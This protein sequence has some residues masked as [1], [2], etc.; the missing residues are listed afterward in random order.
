MRMN[1]IAALAAGVCMVAMATPAQAQERS[2]NIPAG[3]LRSALDAFGRQSGKPII[4]KVDEIRGLRTNG[5][6][7][8][9]APQVALDAI[10]SGTGF[11]ARVAG[12]GAVAIMKTGNVSAAN[13]VPGEAESGADDDSSGGYSDIVVTAQKREERLVDVPISIVA[14]GADE[15]AKREING[16]D[17]LTTAVPGLSVQSAGAWTRRITI[18]GISNVFGASSL[19]G[20]YVDEAS[21]TSGADLQLDL[22]T[23]DL[24]RVEVL[25]GPQG[26]LY[27]EGSVGGTIRFIT[28][29]PQ[30]SNF[31]LT[32]DATASFTEDGAPSQRVEAAVNVP[33]VEDMFGIRVAGTFDHQGGWI[34]Q[35]AASRDNFNSQN[36]TDVRIKALLK[37]SADFRA[38]AMVIIHRNDA[39]TN[40]GE[41]ANGNYLQKFNQLTTPSVTDDFD[42]YNLTLSYDLS[43]VRLLSTS[44]YIDQARAQRN[45]GYILPTG[46]APA[47][48]LDV[49]KPLYSR[50]SQIFSQELRLTSQSGRPWQWTLG[51]FYRDATIDNYNTFYFGVPGA[52]G[53][54]LPGLV[55]APEHRVYESYALFGDTSYKLGRLTLGAGLR[56]FHEDQTLQTA[57]RQTGAFKSFN[58]RVYAQFALG[59]DAN[60]YAS[61]AKGFRSGGFNALNQPAFEP[62][63]VW[64]YELG[65]KA[66]LA[67][68]HLRGDVALFY[69]DY[70]NYQINGFLP[71]PAPPINIFRNA[72]SARIK[73]LEWGLTWTPT[74]AWTFGF[75]G[76]VADTEFYKINTTS[77]SYAVGDPL[78]LFPKYSFTVSAQHNFTA[79]DK[80]GFIRLD[81]N[82]VGRM[83]FRNR[84]SG[85]FY[86]GQSDVI[87]MLNFNSGLDVRENVSL[88][89]FVQNVLNE[90]G[91]LDP[92]VIEQTAAR[93]RPR[94]AGVRLGLRF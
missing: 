93:A 45:Y 6:R 42:L 94:T 1:G 3:N 66:V 44:T 81:Y 48:P 8:T 32:A 47:V 28:R 73:G 67:G 2:F 7:G 41:D 27:G 56:Y 65:A 12:S 25:R 53:T 78:D 51:G 17:D 43:G 61:A 69:S 50:D 30:L 77:A 16:I 90:R 80:P 70:T 38:S 57:T 62:E 35:P 76:Q 83:T 63:K 5:Y 82:Q 74:R 72:G 19:I 26:T 20:V 86:F 52:P 21:A 58:P 87:N 14:M 75:N 68:G 59:R 34:D 36:L 84:R 10:L 4:Y 11:R 37:P 54:P 29:D 64:T 71:A 55:V 22:R 31:G 15:L 33:I 89:V 18:R 24:E 60:I 79:G 13:P 23:Y 9:A 88:G 49:L 46:P 92:L 39:S 91:Y 40:T 85:D